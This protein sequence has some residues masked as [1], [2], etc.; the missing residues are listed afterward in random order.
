MLIASNIIPEQ[1]KLCNMETEGVSTHFPNGQPEH[2]AKKHGEQ[3]PGITPKSP[4]TRTLIRIFTLCIADLRGPKCMCSIR[5]GLFCL[6]QVQSM[7]RHAA[8]WLAL[9]GFMHEIT[10]PSIHKPV[11]KFT[12]LR[13]KERSSSSRRC[14]IYR[15]CG[16]SC[17]GA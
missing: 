5:D 3:G 8:L 11:E 7:Q 2:L 16:T 14:I 12:R 1:R 4:S 15:W 13:K 6:L 17:R 10:S 9:G